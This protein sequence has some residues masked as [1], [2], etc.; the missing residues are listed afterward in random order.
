MGLKTSRDQDSY[1]KNTQNICPKSNSML[2]DLY[3]NIKWW[4][5]VALPL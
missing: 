1:F 4:L 3:E 2:R 5:F